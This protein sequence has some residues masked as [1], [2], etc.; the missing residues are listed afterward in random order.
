MYALAKLYHLTK[1]PEVGRKAMRMYLL[2]VYYVFTMH[3]HVELMNTL[4]NYLM[5]NLMEGDA[6]PGRVL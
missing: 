3:S 6:H 1:E 4:C 5:D 2:C